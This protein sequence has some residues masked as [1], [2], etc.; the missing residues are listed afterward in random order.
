MNDKKQRQT[1]LPTG[2]G[3]SYDQYQGD[4]LSLDAL[5]LQNK[6]A[7][8][9]MRVSGDNA[10]A[11]IEDGDIVIVDKSLEA[12]NNDIVVAVIDAEFVIRRYVVTKESIELYR[13]GEQPSEVYAKNNT[14]ELN[15]LQVWGVVTASITGHRPFV[16]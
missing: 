15:G 12:V 3:G 16:T 4:N 14:E 5:L 9:Y 13:E 6:S 7:T 8:F 1:T 2:F 11:R 10:G